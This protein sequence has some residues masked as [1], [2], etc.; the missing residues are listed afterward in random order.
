[1]TTTHGATSKE[2]SCCSSAAEFAGR[3]RR[4]TVW[5]TVAPGT[6]TN[7]A[8]R[9]DFQ[10]SRN[11]EL[12]V[13]PQLTASDAFFDFVF[14]G[15]GHSYAAL[16]DLA[17]KQEPLPDIALRDVRITITVDAEYQRVQTRL[18]RNVVGLVRGT[19]AKLRDTYVAIGAHL[20]HVGYQQFAPTVGGGGGQL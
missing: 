14:S 3:Q 13:P 16:R 1:M 10:T 2:R 8:Q 6:T 9:T 19:D 4:T 7:N 11:L 12:P 17:A 20:D 15:T 18:T 5:S